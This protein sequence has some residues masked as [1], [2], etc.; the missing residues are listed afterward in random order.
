MGL[1]EKRAAGGDG[2][3]SAAHQQPGPGPARPG[4]LLPAA[5]PPPA[6]AQGVQQV[7]AALL[8]LRPLAA[9]GRARLTQDLGHA[10]QRPLLHRDPGTGRA[11]PRAEGRTERPRRRAALR[12]GPWWCPSG[13]GRMGGPRAPHVWV[14]SPEPNPEDVER[15]REEADGIL[16]HGWRH[17]QHSYPE[18]R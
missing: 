6:G 9:R 7:P 1:S 10:E 15:H 14:T 4:F 12:P 3:V 11:L 2:G 13:T 16:L 17:Q 18:P 8:L 5:R